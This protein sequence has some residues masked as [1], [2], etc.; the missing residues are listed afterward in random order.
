MYLHGIPL[1]YEAIQVS[2]R[3][4]LHKWIEK[5]TGKKDR[6]SPHGSFIC[7]YSTKKTRLKQERYKVLEYNEEHVLI[8][9][10]YTMS[11]GHDQKYL[12]IN[13]NKKE[14]KRKQTGF[15]VCQTRQ[16]PSWQGYK[17]RYQYEQRNKEP[18]KKN[19][20]PASKNVCT[21]VRT[22]SANTFVIWI[23]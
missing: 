17:E 8:G 2:H 15:K 16:V 3:D 21:S 10:H 12:W 11:Q 1:C 6:M 13:I 19:I 22:K 7:C 4:C 5:N 23:H 20:F 18:P 14:G 9:F